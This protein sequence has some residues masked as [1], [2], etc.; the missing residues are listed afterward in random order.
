MLSGAFRDALVKHNGDDAALISAVELNLNTVAGAVALEGGF[1]IIIALDFFAGK[2]G[3]DVAGC[4]AR[5]FGTAALDYGLNVGTHR[6]AI[7]LGVHG[8]ILVVNRASAG[9]CFF[10]IPFLNAVLSMTL[11][12]F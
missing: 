2:S 10:L 5:L 9:V 7:I 12:L 11:H 6:P 1:E 4:N 3:D 8:I